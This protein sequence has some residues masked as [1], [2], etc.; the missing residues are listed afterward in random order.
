MDHNSV[1][2]RIIDEVRR[3]QDDRSI[4]KNNLTE[5]GIFINH[6]PKEGAMMERNSETT[7]FIQSMIAIAAVLLFGAISLTLVS[8]VF[9]PRQLSQVSNVTTPVQ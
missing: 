9:A 6:S 1:R 8:N 2:P 7:L 5:K 3:E 4:E